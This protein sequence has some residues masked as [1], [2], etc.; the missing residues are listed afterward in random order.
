MNSLRNILTILLLLLVFRTTVAEDGIP[1]RGCR[2]GVLPSVTRTNR[3][4]GVQKQV[5]GNFYVGDRRQLVV[6]VSFADQQFM[7]T[8]PLPVW[9]RIF[10][11]PNYTEPP[12]YGSVYDYFYAQSGG[13]FRLS[14][15]LLYI[16]LDQN[17][18]R[19]HSTPG[20]M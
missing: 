18:E 5:G 9:D 13:Q 14:F 2:R 20:H 17:R 6:L 1:M 19:Y 11:E 15:D 4:A 8:D 16:A 7:Q 10:N 3:A 12:F